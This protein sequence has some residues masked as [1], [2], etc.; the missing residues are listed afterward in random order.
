MNVHWIPT[1]QLL[2]TCH[3][4]RG[5]LTYLFY[6]SY[7]CCC[8]LEPVEITVWTAKMSRSWETGLT[9]AFTRKNLLSHSRPWSWPWVCGIGLGLGLGTSGLVN[10][11][12]GVVR[13]EFGL[14]IKSWR[15]AY[16]GYANANSP[17]SIAFSCGVFG[18]MAKCKR[19]S[20]SELD[21]NV[22][23]CKE[24]T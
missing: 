8:S 1:F 2:S 13:L 10:I 16:N 20:S 19:P 4:K 18:T 6:C 24:I 21:S 9:L 11:L 23:V 3:K 5:L 14:V 12:G 15:F 7:Y 17:Q 22:I